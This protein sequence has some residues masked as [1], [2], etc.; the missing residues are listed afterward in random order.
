MG[1]NSESKETVDRENMLQYIT[2][3]D[4]KA[5]GLIPELLGRLP[6]LTYLD[7]LDHEALKRIL[8]EPKNALIKQYKKLFSMEGIQL[9]FSDG[10]LDFIVSK[11]M[12][13]KLGARGLR[14]ICEAIMTDAMFELPSKKDIKEFI[15]TE[16]YAMEK[17]S[18][19]KL[20]RLKAA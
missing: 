2:H 7:P 9:S 10:A 1:F 11:A 14:S 17:I 13:F 3:Q 6:V 5:Y 20:A 16:E 12:E 15:V 18:R 4:T 8:V 19:S